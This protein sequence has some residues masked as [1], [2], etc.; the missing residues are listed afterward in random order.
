MM[1]KID[2]R[3]AFDTMDRSFLIRVLVARGMPQSWIRWICSLLSDTQSNLIVNGEVQ[4]SF[5]CF[6]GVRQVDPLSPYL[7]ILVMDVLS[8]LLLKAQGNGLI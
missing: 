8:D 3:K 5:Q 6:T 4:P 7:F 1:F 2:L